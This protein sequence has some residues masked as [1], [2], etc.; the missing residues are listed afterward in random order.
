MGSAAPAGPE[1]VRAPAVRGADRE[2]AARA[3]SA[4]SA[5]RVGLLV[6]AARVERGGRAASAAPREALASTIPT[7]RSFR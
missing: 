6:K 5:L 3:V 7:S 4:A 2:L 1:V